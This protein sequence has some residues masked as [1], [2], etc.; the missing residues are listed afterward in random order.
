MYNII[1][2]DSSIHKDFVEATIINSMK[3]LYRSMNSELYFL[4]A[5]AYIQNILSLY[6]VNVAVDPEDTSHIYGFIVYKAKTYEPNQ[7]F[8][9]Y[10]KSTFRCNGIGTSL[11]LPLHTSRH[12]Y[13]NLENSKVSLF[14]KSINLS[15]WYQPFIMEI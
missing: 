10:V 2:Y 1:P 3:P 11:C 4:H 9:L 13:M 15:P 8:F 6:T 12:V 7:V 14:L 5:R